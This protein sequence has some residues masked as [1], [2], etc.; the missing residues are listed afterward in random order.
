MPLLYRSILQD[1]GNDLPTS[2]DRLFT[3]WLGSKGVDVSGVDLDD[4][5]GVELDDQSGNRVLVQRRAVA[6]PAPRKTAPPRAERFRLV[7]HTNLGRWS[8]TV[9]VFSPSPRQA[10]LFA[11]GTSE[12]AQGTLDLDGGTASSWA[13]VDL[14]FE[15]SSPGDTV[16]PGSPRLVRDLM[17]AG[18]VHDGGVPLTAEPW[19]IRKA[20]VPELVRHIRSPDRQVPVMVFASDAQ[21]AYDRD[22]LAA[23]LAR[24]LAGVAA[25]FLLEDAAATEALAR[26]LPEGLG[27]YAGA[28]RTY[29]PGAGTEGDEPSRHRVLG[30]TSI[31]AMRARAFPAVRD[32]VLRLST[33]RPAPPEAEAIRRLM[34][35]VEARATEPRDPSDSAPLVRSLLAWVNLQI[36]RVR[37]ALGAATVDAPPTSLPAAQDLLEHEIDRLIHRPASGPPQSPDLNN[38]NEEL[39]RLSEQ[40]AKVSDERAT[41]EALLSEADDEVRAFRA[42]ADDEQ[43]TRQY[44]ELELAEISRQDADLRRRLAFLERRERERGERVVAEVDPVPAPTSVADA[45]SLARETLSQVVLGNVEETA[46]ELDV[47]TGGELYA[48]KTWAALQALND[49][50]V[51]RS[52]A[53]FAG[54]FYQ[55]CQQRPEGAWGMSTAAVAMGESESV[56]DN[57]DLRAKRMFPVPRE[58]DAEGRAYMPAHIKIVKRGS[59]C[60]RLHFLD[61]AGG[62]TGKVYVGYIGEHLPTARFR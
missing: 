17:A 4:R 50:A 39:T 18:E 9:T 56:N 43:L 28:L 52:A 13:W 36:V 31:A 32:H 45:V 6:L 19:R 53:Q 14:E 12:T 42:L 16:R 24:D 1:G 34:A 26:E 8:T 3:Q 47:H 37:L 33:Q 58:V 29:L 21:R 54:S 49:Y 27:V 5:R 25:V 2:V 48:A 61:D 55:W 62:A 38:A 46:A 15:P 20:H 30:R 44:L 7:E 23:L 51:A 41:Y 60:P 57:P 10:E 40:L 59:P 22:R 35:D 11:S